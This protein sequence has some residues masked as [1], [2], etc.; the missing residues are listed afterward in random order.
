MIKLELLLHEDQIDTAKEALREI[1]IRKM[2][3]SDVKDYD[4]EHTHVES[5]RGSTYV[6]EFVQKVKMEILLNSEDM[7]DRALHI[8]SVAN[9]EAEVLLYPISKQFNITKRE[10]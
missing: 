7:I 4:E 9:I 3:L 6:I 1:G 5:Y 2:I 8:L 10:S